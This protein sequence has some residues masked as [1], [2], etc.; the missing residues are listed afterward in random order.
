ML[1]HSVMLVAAAQ[2]MVWTRSGQSSTLNDVS[3]YADNAEANVPPPPAARRR[4]ASTWVQPVMCLRGCLVIKLPG[5]LS[6]ICI[7]L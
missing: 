7:G 4:P 5:S 1:E 3:V 2:V 6:L